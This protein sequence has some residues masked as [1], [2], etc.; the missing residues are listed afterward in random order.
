MCGSTPSGLGGLAAL[1]G[2]VRLGPGLVE[3]DLQLAL[4][5]VERLLGLVDA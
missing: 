1:T 5:V 2:A 3:R 4:E